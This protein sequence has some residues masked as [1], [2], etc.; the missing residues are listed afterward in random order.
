MYVTS[1]RLR[2]RRRANCGYLGNPCPKS[3]RFANAS[4]EAFEDSLSSKSFRSRFANSKLFRAS[5]TG[6]SQAKPIFTILICTLLLSS[7]VFAEEYAN[8]TNSGGDSFVKQITKIINFIFFNNSI[9][10]MLVLENGTPL[11]NQELLF[12]ENETAFSSGTTNESGTASADYAPALGEHNISVI[13]GGTENLS[14]SGIF[15]TINIGGAE[16]ETANNETGNITEPK[17]IIGE[18]ID[19]FLSKL[20]IIRGEI[21]T[22]SAQ[23]AY[24]NSTP[25]PGEELKF[26][27][28]SSYLGSNIT[29]E[30]GSAV[31]SVNTSEKYI[32]NFTINVTHGAF[33]NV[34]VVEIIAP[35]NS[36]NEI[37]STANFSENA[38][39][40]LNATENSSA[41]ITAPLNERNITVE[42][43]GATQ[44]FAETGKPV[45]WTKKIRIKNNA[46][47]IAAHLINISIDGD[48]TNIIVE[49]DASKKEIKINAKGG[50]GIASIKN[51]TDF[52]FG[53]T[54]A[55]L[56]EKEYTVEYETPAPLKIESENET[57]GAEWKKKVTVFS[58]YSY[59]NVSS[60]TDITESG[61]ANIHLFW[62]VSGVL[63]DVTQDPTINLTYVDTNGNGKIDRI[64]WIVPHLSEQEFVVVV[65]LTVINAQS[66]PTVGGNWTVMF[67]TTGTANLTISAIGE[68]LWSNDTEEKDLKFLEL[69]CGENIVAPVW[70]N[71]SVFIE[72]YFCNETS[73][74][75]SKV[76]TSG[77]HHL[78]FRFG[79]DV[80]YA[81]NLAGCSLSCDSASNNVCIISSPKE[82]LTD[83]YIDDNVLGGNTSIEIQSGGSIY[84]NTNAAS[85]MINVTG[86][87]TIK[88]GGNISGNVNISAVNLTIESGGSI[89]ANGKGYTGGFGP[90]AGANAAS[91]QSKG[92]GYGG[93]GGLNNGVP[94]GNITAPGD[95]GSGG[96]NRTSAPETAGGSGGGLVR[97]IVSGTLTNNGSI[98]ADGTKGSVTYNLGG[99]SG[100]GIYLNTSAFAGN[101]SIT[102]NGGAGGGSSDA[103]H[104]G[105][106]RVAIY[107]DA[108]TFSG[109]ISAYGATG[110]SYPIIGGAGTI[111]LKNSSK[112]Y[113]D[114]IVDNNGNSG[115]NT[116]LDSSVYST[117]FDTV[118][119]SNAGRVTSTIST[120]SLNATKILG[121]SNLSIEDNNLDL[122][123]S[124]I[125]MSGGA[126]TSE[127]GQINITFI[128]NINT[129]N[130]NTTISTSS[131]AIRLWY[132]STPQDR[133]DVSGATI[134]GTASYYYAPWSNT[135]AYRCI[136]AIIID[137]QGI[138]DA[139]NTSR[140]Q[141]NTNEVFYPSIR[142]REYNGTDYFDAGGSWNL[143]IYNSNG[144]VLNTTHNT[145]N[146]TTSYFWKTQS[147]YSE[148]TA[149]SYSFYS[150]ITGISSAGMANYSN[151]SMHTY[152]VK[153]ISVT[154]S[155]NATNQIANPADTI[156]ISG[157]AVLQPDGTDVTGRN[158]SIYLNGAFQ[159]NSTTNSTGHYNY[160]FTAPQTAG[161]HTVKV[162][163]TDANGIYGSNETNLSVRINL[164]SPNAVSLG[165]GDFNITVTILSGNINYPAQNISNVWANVT[166]SGGSETISLSGNVSGGVWNN[167]HS[168]RWGTH[169]IT[170]YVNLTDGF[171]TTTA[172][173][174]TFSNPNVTR[175]QDLVT[176]NQVYTLT[177]NVSS[178]GTC[179]NVLADNITLDGQWYMV[180]YS[181]SVT[182]YGVNITNRN[183]VTVKNLNVV[184]GNSSV[185]SAKGMYLSGTNTSTVKGNL[186]RTSGI[187]SYGVELITS[188]LNNLTNNTVFAPSAGGTNFVVLVN[189]NSNANRLIN[190]T[191]IDS[192][193]HPMIRI[194]GQS[195]NNIIMGG[196]ISNL[197][198]GPSYELYGA[199]TT[200][201]F[202]ETN[203]TASRKIS[204]YDNTSWFNYNN[205]TNGNIWLKTRVTTAAVIS[206]NRTLSTWSQAQMT[207]NDTN[208]STASTTEYNLTGL[209]ASTTYAVYNTSGGIKQKS[210][211]L[212]T[213]STGILPSFTIAL[214]GNTEIRADNRYLV[215][216]QFNIS[217]SNG[218]LSGILNPGEPYNLSVRIQETNGTQNW[219]VSSGSFNITVGGTDYLLVYTGANSVWRTQA[220]YGNA[221]SSLGTYSFLANISGSSSP[222][223]II[224]SLNNAN[225]T[226]YVKQLNITYQIN[227]SAIYAAESALINGT[228]Y[229][230]PEHAVSANTPINITLNSGSTDAG[231][232][233]TGG[234][235]RYNFTY[236]PPA[237]SAIT[238]INFTLNATDTDGITNYTASPQA[239]ITVYP[240][241]AV[242]TW[243]SASSSCA[244]RDT[245]FNITGEKYLCANVTYGTNKTAGAYVN[246]SV[247]DIG[248]YSYGPANPVFANNSVYDSGTIVSSPASLNESM[249]YRITA[250]VWNPS[251]NAAATA[252]DTY[253]FSYGALNLSATLNDTIV[254]PNSNISLSGGVFDYFNQSWI[255]ANNSLF[256]YLDE[257][258]LTNGGSYSKIWATNANFSN[259]TSVNVTNSSNGLILD[260]RGNYYFEAENSFANDS[261]DMKDKGSFAWDA[262][263][264]GDKYIM[265]STTTAWAKYNITNIPNGTYYIFVKLYS[266]G[267]NYMVNVTWDGAYV[268]TTQRSGGYAAGMLWSD[269]LGTTI[270]VNSTSHILGINATVDAPSIDAI[271]LTTNN[272]YIPNASYQNYSSTSLKYKGYFTSNKTTADYPI[273][274]ITPNWTGNTP[275]GTNLT[276]D[277]SADNGATWCT[278]A[279][280]L[281]EYRS[282][283]GIGTGTELV[284]RANLSTGSAP[285]TLRLDTLAISYETGNATKTNSSGN[286]SFSFNAGSTL[287]WHTIKIN[288]TDSEGIRGNIS[289]T[290]YLDNFSISTGTT[291]N[292][293]DVDSLSETINVTIYSNSGRT[294]GKRYN[295]TA[296]TINPDSTQDIIANSSFS[297]T[298]NYPMNCTATWAP[299]TQPTGW[300]NVTISFVDNESITG[301]NTTY[302]DFNVDN[303]TTTLISSDI[304]PVIAKNITISGTAMTYSSAV[305]KAAN[306]TITTSASATHLCGY[307]TTM[308][309]AQYS[310]SI[311]CSIDSA[312]YSNELG[313]ATVTARLNDTSGSIS[314]INATSITIWAPTKVNY[315]NSTGY[316]GTN[317]EYNITGDYWRTDVLGIIPG[318]INIT[319][320]N[321]TYNI[322]KS[323]SGT[324]T[325]LKNFTIGPTGELAGGNYTVYINASNSSAYYMPNS[326]QYKIYL[327]EPKATGTLNVANKVISDM[328]YGVDYSFNET[329]TLNNSNAATMFNSQINNY[330]GCSNIRSVKNLTSRECSGTS[331]SSS[332]EVRFNI[333]VWGGACSVPPCDITCVSWNSSW[334]NNDNTQSSATKDDYTIII[335]G[336]PKMNLS[337]TLINITNNIGNTNSTQLIVNNTGNEKL[338]NDGSAA[339]RVS[340]DFINQT[341]PLSWVS[342]YSSTQWNDAEDYWNFINPASS[343]ALQ[344]NI[345]ADNYTAGTYT[346]IINITAYR[347]GVLQTYSEINVSITIAPNFTISQNLINHTSY[348]GAPNITDIIL[349]GSGNA[350]VTNVTI[351]YIEETMNASW[352]NFSSPDAGWNASTLS[353]DRVTEY[354]NK[355]LKVNITVLNYTSGTY[356]GKINITT[357]EGISRLINVTTTVSPAMALSEYEINITQNISAGNSTIVY[358]QG[359]GN[360]PITNITVALVN[361]TI[362]SNWIILSSNESEWN[363]SL[364]SYSR[365]DEETNR[366]LN[367]TIK[368]TN[369]TEGT[370]IGILNIT[371]NE[372]QNTQINL[373]ITI[374]PNATAPNMNTAEEHGRIT[375][376]S[377]IINSTGNAPL[378]NATARYV[379][380]TLPS[381]WVT[382]KYGGQS[383][384]SINAGNVT[385]GNYTNI[386]VEISIPS[387]QAPGNYVGYINTTFNNEPEKQ[388]TLTLTVNTNSS[389]YLLAPVN[390]SK[391][392]DLGSS[393]GELG[394]VGNVTIVNTGNVPL[395]Y[396]I[397]YTKNQECNNYGCMSGGTSLGYNNASVYVQKNSNATFNIWQKGDFSTHTDTE[398]IANISNSSGTPTELLA[399]MRWNITNAAPKLVNLTTLANSYIELNKSITLFAILSDDEDR[400]IDSAKGLNMSSVYFNITDPT[401][402]T[403]TITNE[404]IYWWDENDH[405]GAEQDRKHFNYSFANT[406]VEGIH[407]LT[408][409][410]KDMSNNEIN[411]S[412]FQFEVIGATSLKLNVSNPSTATNI[413]LLHG[414]NL[415]VPINIT[416]IGKATAYNITLTG[417]FSNGIIWN[418]TF[419]QINESQLIQTNITVEV[420]AGTQY[421]PGGYQLMP[422]VL[423]I[424]PNISWSENISSS[425]ITISVAPNPEISVSPQMSVFINHSQGKSIVI[426]VN[427]TGNANYLGANSYIIAGSTQLNWT[428]IDAYCG[429]TY[430]KSQGSIYAGDNLSTN[431]FIR[432]PSGTAPGNYTFYFKTNSSAYPAGK[433]TN[434][435][436]TVLEDRSWTSSQ[437][438]NASTFELNTPGIFGIITL[439]GSGNIG[440]NYSI[441]YSNWSDTDYH[442]I[443]GFFNESQN[444][445]GVIVNPTSMTLEPNELKNITL[446]HNGYSQGMENIGI[447]IT[448]SNSSAQP[449]IQSLLYVFNLTETPPQITN[450]TFFNASYVELNKT[451]GIKV[452]ARDDAALNLS[453]ILLNITGPT[454][455]LTSVIP[456]T[457][458]ENQTAS[459]KYL[460]MNFTYLFNATSIAG[461][462]TANA[463]IYDEHGY[464]N[465]SA[466]YK[467]EVIGATTMSLAPNATAYNV[468][469]ITQNTSR[470][471]TLMINATNTGLVNAYNA[472]LSGNMGVNA[473]SWM[474][475]STPLGN[476]SASVISA[477]NI[478]IHMPE[479]TWPGTY[480]FTPRINWTQPNGSIAEYNSS[481]VPIIVASNRTVMFSEYSLNYTIGHGT[482]NTTLIRINS[483]GNDNATSINLVKQ[484][485]P[486]NITVS[487]SPATIPSIAAGNSSYVTIN[488]SAIT[489]APNNTYSFD[490]RLDNDGS[491][492]NTYHY[493]V[494]V[495]ASFSWSK[496]TNTTIVNGV[497]GQNAIDTSVNITNRGNNPITFAFYLSG[498]ITNTPAIMEL[499]DSSK[500]LQPLEIYAIPLNHTAH[501]DAELYEYYSGTLEI[502]SNGSYSETVSIGYN[503]YVAELNIIN[504][505][506]SYDIIAGNS[507]NVTTQVVF[508][509]NNITENTTYSIKINGTSCPISQ[510][511][512]QGSYI[513]HT[514]AAPS[515]ADGKY[516]DLEANADYSFQTGIVHITHTNSSATYY[517]DITAPKI[518]THAI[519]SGQEILKNVSINLTLEDNIKIDSAIAKIDYPNSTFYRNISLS[520][521]TASNYSAVFEAPE[522]T[523]YY[524]ATYYVNDT[525]GNVNSSIQD[526]F[527]IYEWKNF[528]GTIQ[529]LDLN[530][531]SVL[532]NITNSSGSI[533][534]LFQTNASGYY[535][536]TLKTKLYNLEMSFFNSTIKMADV[537]F[538]TLPLDFID[539][540]QPMTGDYGFDGTV[541][542]GF[543][544]NSTLPSSGNIT[545]TYTQ[546]EAAGLTT[547]YFQIYQCSNWDYAERNCYSGLSR[548]TG[549]HDK[550]NRKLRAPFVAFSTFLLVEDAPVSRPQLT[551]AS[552]TISMTV[553]HGKKGAGFLTIQSTG[554]V[555]LI[556]IQ[557]SCISGTACTDFTFAAS[558]IVGLDGGASY[559]EP[560][561]VTVPKYYAPGMYEGILAIRS[562][563]GSVYEQYKEVT[564][565]VTVPEDNN[566]TAIS[567]LTLENAGSSIN[568]I[569]GNISIQNLANVPIYFTVTPNTSVIGALP[570]EATISK[571]NSAEITINYTAPESVS[572]YNYSINISGGGNSS[573]VYATMNLTHAV[574][575]TAIEPIMNISAGQTIVINAT[576]N[577]LGALQAD[578]VSWEAL[579]DD[580]PCTSISSS[581][582]ATKW[583]LLCEAPNMSAKL[584]YRL[585]VKGTFMKLGGIIAYDSAYDVDNIYYVDVL[586]PQVANTTNSAEQT[587][588]NVTV[589]ATIIDS[590][591]VSYAIVTIIAPNGTSLDVFNTT[592]VANNTFSFSYNFTDIGDYILRY[593]VSDSLNNSGTADRFFEVYK[594]ITFAGSILI[595]NGSGL[596][597]TVKLYRQNQNY[598]GSHL[599]QQFTTDSSGYYNKTVHTRN[600]DLELD[601]PSVVA[602][603]NNAIK[604]YDVNIT[605]YTSDPIDID[606]VF[607]NQVQISGTEEIGGIAVKTNITSAGRITLAYYSDA[608]V[609]EDNIY[610]YKCADWNYTKGSCSGSWEKL[611]REESDL[612]K[613]SDQISAD[614][615]GFSAYVAAEITP[616]IIV[617]ITSPSQST[618]TSSSGGTGDYSGAISDIKQKLTSLIEGTS[619]FS[620][621]TKSIS[622]QLY[623]G[624]RISISLG[625]KN[626][627]N[628][629]ATMTARV[630]G[631]LSNFTTLEKN[632]LD[633]GGQ[634]SGTFAMELFIPRTAY[635]GNYEGKVIINNG[636][637]D[638]VVPVSVRVL[639]S[640]NIPITVDV[641]PLMDKV[642]PGA[643]ARVKLSFINTGANEVPINYTLSVVDPMSGVVVTEVKGSANIVSAESFYLNISIPKNIT[644][645]TPTF[646]GLSNVRTK[647]YMVR[648]TA[649][650]TAP[651][652]NI[653]AETVSFMSVTETMSVWKVSYLGI[654]L[655]I[656]IESILLTISGYFIRKRYVVWANSKKKYLASIDFKTLPQATLRAGHVG[657]IA[658]TD[659]RAFIDF[660][661]LQTHTVVAGSSG[662]GKTVAAQVIV[663]EALLKGVST[664]VFDPTAQWTGFLRPNRD[665]R[666]LRMYG[667]F[668][669]KVADSRA[670]DGNIYE[671]K[672][673]GQIIDITKFI[674]PGQ[675]TIFTMNHMD[676]KDID[677][678]VANTVKQVFHAGLEE[679]QRLRLLIVYDEVHRL[680]QKYGGSGDGFLQIERAVR[681]FRKWGVGLLLI[682]Q[683][684]SDFVG[685]IKANIGTDIQLRTRDE[686]DLDRIKMKYGEDLMRSTVK[687]AVGEA[688]VENAQYNKGKPYFVAFR[689]LLHSIER[690]SDKDLESY[691]RYNTKID[692]LKYQLECLKA[693]AVDV[694]DLEL[695]LK[696]SLD[697]LM[698]GKFNMVD[699]YLEE[700]EPKVASI[701]K[702]IGK[703]PKKRVIAYA[704][705]DEIQK[706]VERAKRE[707]EDYM[708]K[709]KLEEDK[710]KQSA[711]AR[712]T[713]AAPAAKENDTV[714]PANPEA[715][716][717]QEKEKISH[718][719][720][721]AYPA[722]N[723]GFPGAKEAG[724]PESPK[725]PP[726]APAPERKEAHH[727]A[728][729]RKKELDSIKAAVIRDVRDRAKKEDLKMGIK[730][731]ADVPVQKKA[732]AKT[733]ELE[734]LEAEVQALYQS[735]K[736]KMSES[737]RKGTDTSFVSLKAMSIPA[738]I[739]L[740]MVDGNMDALSK[741]KGKINS[742]MKN[743]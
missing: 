500:T 627:L 352:I 442:G 479:A 58:N 99:G 273:I 397:T 638:T 264:S 235:G 341:M 62:N 683:V 688:M 652:Q 197:G 31:L 409:Y 659:I 249:K 196:T 198:S 193:P 408:V 714:P 596:Q 365:I 317:T 118:N 180:N 112:T 443:G 59:K 242:D 394:I 262:N 189:T 679:S 655:W 595:W 431:V 669:M 538:F 224:D 201:N 741:I 474:I 344:V 325:C 729:H 616:P 243:A 119:I 159:A 241:I 340:V 95:F 176:P 738:D 167:T 445:S 257:N 209:M 667:D 628:K 547:D 441:S 349:N 676:T 43:F 2:E 645:E 100:G 142:I 455:I 735:L 345:T 335:S 542:K 140:T 539:I 4:L 648:A 47:E 247:S 332:C 428:C 656:I 584:S 574:N 261:F 554:T 571:N 451:I 27:E 207:W 642:A 357:N 13:F 480:Y 644:L 308:S 505:T 421:A 379:A 374:D 462:Y 158:A 376:I 109:T 631:E 463:S 148:S 405:Q 449:P 69:K 315:T 152:S 742:L 314:G 639:D 132:G 87:I 528:S 739:K 353:F 681:E 199:S 684:L 350:P 469:G 423:W 378:I 114:L 458:S 560:V 135:S 334:T 231:G 529:T 609:K 1:R 464:S 373:S 171:S 355:T 424:D 546:E 564:L 499:T 35:D 453:A 534:A 212:T 710:K 48:A 139:S 15:G 629:T 573:L 10:A 37:N 71:D 478:T 487:L 222:N 19:I 346:G 80:E 195:Q 339:S 568:G 651:G 457:T 356:T 737:N 701:W 413:T 380:S 97:L 364:N 88:S 232:K 348:I 523:G 401:G 361:N 173:N 203:F 419:S 396:T 120:L 73:Y 436:I 233:I 484:N 502:W 236:T 386:T 622:K 576:A 138:M 650:S 39:S 680:L 277:I 301:T 709:Q 537:N 77:K 579:V 56:E 323:C 712:A 156:L 18:M 586:P 225:Y 602:S 363:S 649:Y 718:E 268:N 65:D 477:G 497:S 26:Y 166:W 292:L 630:L 40:E 86:N 3:S 548:L 412:V 468:S 437:P 358:I 704:T 144:S 265:A 600:Y 700:L 170:F 482:T 555:S 223:E 399:Y 172:A 137:N 9:T 514:C 183:N 291:P 550:I 368:A 572:F 309:G 520:N 36:T 532:F 515:I 664:I 612:D 620:V 244:S 654:P 466:Q 682:S 594:N 24:D 666:M 116:P 603:K 495:P 306:I 470:N 21:L 324:S 287:G 707:R 67:T 6:K 255:R 281:Q 660:D 673:P 312:G 391:I 184:Q 663:E 305:L 351:K 163:L 45:V 133:C 68:T 569:L 697:N 321:S 657:K 513:V 434:I 366:I 134:S 149:A 274:S 717:V 496:N 549:T 635:P 607:G 300:Y 157:K 101:G 371:S 151:S 501:N 606:K 90:G 333:T 400:D 640:R 593:A 589:N 194:S 14:A 570:T 96:G 169:N 238:N 110:G 161:N 597:T 585:T 658:E 192:A 290:Y 438:Y 598:S 407:N 5:S 418:R 694:F 662:G 370:Y 307:N 646:E 98:T 248:S 214:N 190:N 251:V 121:N 720:P 699:I 608:T 205:Q 279:T 454:G 492:M 53:E 619:E 216:D 276:I 562:N 20:S 150:N 715:P 430:A 229:S 354:T 221:Q 444:N 269:N 736:E 278:N 11:A 129:S 544:V 204:F 485:V 583:V 668:D 130:F 473:S 187:S 181:T 491:T 459:G 330:S 724:K 432:T 422:K 79:D 493:T 435:T 731:A 78:M 343:Y 319:V 8:S 146:T 678:F 136:R 154:E 527:E 388:A 510:A 297:C 605:K 625:V 211:T 689:P 563:S 126:I 512:Q 395:N 63:V 186:V 28:D 633:L 575:I 32:G 22:I 467:F 74:E 82:V 404:S 23:L 533:I 686:N 162:N 398:I 55:P 61:K 89:T 7:M 591:N 282:G 206:L 392:F 270:T 320:F 624:E 426:Y 517:K 385:E 72:N 52:E 653:K 410:I 217:D 359:S 420:N 54:L 456:N 182:G 553:G 721:D 362:P 42:E 377:Y 46:G 122:R 213:S 403:Y 318:I 64:Y 147:A 507:I 70:T 117:A 472:T 526:I 102:A 414:E 174:A 733:S 60:Y 375:N 732:P 177:K 66:Y 439:N 105:G 695:E 271:L 155:L 611:E 202:T 674:L 191:L 471:I 200:N 258:L 705:R 338:G 535:N 618:T 581:Y 706:E 614:I 369:Y 336:N 316:A 740:A 509:T 34:S 402:Y 531:V 108:K 551:I 522:T 621:D 382:L 698:K 488:I 561:N 30:N 416:N 637:V 179:F 160:T 76:L 92:A 582:N 506:P 450:I 284:W 643:V 448:I 263:S 38:S 661:T 50:F 541:V 719:N 516:Y 175:C 329:L 220:A 460:K 498:N 104:G 433:T 677:F 632:T 347:L 508:G 734:E 125:S 326:T 665:K 417:V 725:E 599:L 387:Y 311:N 25:I 703:E 289:T 259:G 580:T 288:A 91:I 178:A 743:L 390:K 610:I 565:K 722:Q 215:F 49:N 93:Y 240:Q 283:C 687:S 331:P 228:V 556:N 521:T 452:H 545:M 447:N 670:F 226:Y 103:F 483:T 494:V 337:L 713:P 272:S 303:I 519:T 406:S 285:S 647:R 111:Y 691:S 44:G 153:G 578:N 294:S 145:T 372:F 360:A 429:A 81:N 16:N 286:Y 230:E 245:A 17:T 702:K 246:F 239:A 260:P 304:A 107:Y 106:G 557:F 322:S 256:I 672:D 389:W 143:T 543:A 530:P 393:S 188:S 425:N 33:W 427:S 267:G 113:G 367:V 293:A 342:F 164:T 131:G 623:P 511:V 636:K 518:N 675:I 489:G 253:D 475:Y 690:L 302:N 481:P 29:D 559:D 219:T 728:E 227:D 588:S 51:K 115:A 696:L 12:Y 381:D 504:I 94:Y 128:N 252:Q 604:L 540:D 83:C 716:Q 486:A 592:K 461:N 208:I 446:Y 613:I 384:S 250:T 75:I 692:D 587:S 730:K 476:I 84:N 693:E 280:N 328:V 601:A 726:R 185:S 552:S 85:F 577:Y 298:N 123:V 626:G 723:R 296:T 490:I 415:T 299:G 237:A 503:S 558:S 567:N 671:I 711:P 634:E 727:S 168:S 275:A 165:N 210:Y 615:T 708:K 685:T 310:W 536:T 617:N 411:I 524:F 254:M 141:L 440:A 266:N 41:N 641:Q 566:W 525:T 218:Q 57:S 383:G 124:N 234:S 590:S 127:S 313:P 295:I 327:E 465:Q